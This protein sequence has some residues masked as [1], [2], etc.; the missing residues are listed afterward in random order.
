MILHRIGLN[1]GPEK[2]LPARVFDIGRAG[3][4][5]APYGLG[6][7]WGITSAGRRGTISAR[8]F[9]ARIRFD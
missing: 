4:F 9:F 6:S 2:H 5:C 3:L 7:I 1:R 8:R